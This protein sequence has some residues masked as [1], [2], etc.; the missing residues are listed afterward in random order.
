MPWSTV[1]QCILRSAWT[2]IADEVAISAVALPFKQHAVEADAVLMSSKQEA[3]F[4][5]FRERL[6]DAALISVSFYHVTALIAVAGA[7]H[8]ATSTCSPAP[9]TRHLCS[10]CTVGRV[11]GRVRGLGSRVWV[12]V[13][14]PQ[15]RP[16]AACNLV[17]KAW[18]GERVA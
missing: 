2:G 7:R 12:R 3:A 17:V 6:P 13:R 18:S 4:D 11:Q 16:G 1:G 10:T 8:V 15:C 14:L 5:G 9:H